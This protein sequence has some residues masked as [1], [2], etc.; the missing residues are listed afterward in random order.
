L[1]PIGYKVIRSNANGGVT[2]VDK[3]GDQVFSLLEEAWRKIAQARGIVFATA[4]YRVCDTRAAVK[5]FPVV[6]PQ[7][8]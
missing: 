3:V 7:S 6:R 2:K 8:E 1:C 4:A 5:S